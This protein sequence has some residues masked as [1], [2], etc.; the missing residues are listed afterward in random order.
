MRF[1]QL[2]NPSL[3][4]HRILIRIKFHTGQTYRVVF[5]GPK[6]ADKGLYDIL[7][8]LRSELPKAKIEV[9]ISAIDD[10]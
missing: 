10:D 6:E 9:Q 1:P 5:K 2:E 3:L 4:N 8:T 7:G